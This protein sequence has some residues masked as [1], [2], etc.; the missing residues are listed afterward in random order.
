MQ[1]SLFDFRGAACPISSKFLKINI[2][3]VNG[4][5]DEYWAIGYLFFVLIMFDYVLVIGSITSCCTFFCLIMY[6]SFVV[7]LLKGRY[8]R[9]VEFYLKKN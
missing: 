4:V 6:Y 3:D 5:V 2:S 9:T 7:L 8:N 1:S